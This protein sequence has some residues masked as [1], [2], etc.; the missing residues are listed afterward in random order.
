[1]CPTNVTGRPG[2]ITSQMWVD[3]TCRPS[4][5]ATLRGHGVVRLFVTGVPSMMKICV[6][7][8]SAM[9][10][11]CAM[12]IAAWAQS[13]VRGGEMGPVGETFDATMVLALTSRLS[14]ANPQICV[15]YDNEARRVGYDEYSVT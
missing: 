6:A 15:G 7:P 2:I 12:G 8:E 4:A 13:I 10:T 14:L 11:W 5:S 9:A 1:M 3:K